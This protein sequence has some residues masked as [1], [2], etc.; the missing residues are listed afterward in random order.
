MLSLF[1]PQL[2]LELTRQKAPDFWS[3]AVI[4]CAVE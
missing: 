2:T 4:G 3:G 1:A